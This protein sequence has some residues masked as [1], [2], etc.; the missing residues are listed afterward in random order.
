MKSNG[1]IDYKAM[2][3][4]LAFFAILTFVASSATGQ[5]RMSH[6]VKVEKH[7]DKVD[8]NPYY[9]EINRLEDCIEWIKS[10]VEHG[11]IEGFVAEM[12]IN[13]IE[14][15]VIALQKGPYVAYKQH[16][17][18]KEREYTSEIESGDTQ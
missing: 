6:G 9:E 13:T 10:D 18:N 12:Y 7:I 1:K 11:M 17:Y 4:V 14:D 5:I 3:L 2:L 8:I 15:V 16:Q